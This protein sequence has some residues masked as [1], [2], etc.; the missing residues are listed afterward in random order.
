MAN[1]VTKELDGEV[2]KETPKPHQVTTLFV[3][4]LTK[5]FLRMAFKAFKAFI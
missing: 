4:F 2:V 1:E 5:F 3:I